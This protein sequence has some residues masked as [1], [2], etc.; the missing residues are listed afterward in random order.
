[1]CYIFAFEVYFTSTESHT[2][3]T[4]LDVT[5]LSQIFLVEHKIKKCPVCPVWNLV[6]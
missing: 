2:Y 4:S 5:D 3:L 1:M 6:T